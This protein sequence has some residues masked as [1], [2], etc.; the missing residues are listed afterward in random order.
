MLFLSNAYGSTTVNEALGSCKSEFSS[1]LTDAKMELISNSIWNYDND[2]YLE[3]VQ[4]S[5]SAADGKNIVEVYVYFDIEGLRD[6]GFAYS[7]QPYFE[8]KNKE[9]CSYIDVDLI[10]AD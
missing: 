2:Y 9:F 8:G 10:S 5:L 1:Y 4:T 3:D 6:R 7:F